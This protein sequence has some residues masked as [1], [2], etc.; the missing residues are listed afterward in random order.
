MIAAVR[1]RPSFGKIVFAGRP[2]PP[3]GHARPAIAGTVSVY[4]RAGDRLTATH[5]RKDS[6]SSSLA[7]GRY[8]LN[9]GTKLH[10]SAANGCH[11]ARAR[12]RPD[13]TTRVQVGTGCA[14]P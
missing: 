5:V 1:E 3:P 4:T 10:Y 14:I 8:L 6:V 9:A 13:K 7:P 11:L 12:V 2:H